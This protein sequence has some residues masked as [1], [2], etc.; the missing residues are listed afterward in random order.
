MYLNLIRQFGTV[1]FDVS[2]DR[3]APKLVTPSDV[4]CGSFYLGTESHEQVQKLLV[5]LLEHTASMP[6]KKAVKVIQKKLAKFR[7]EDWRE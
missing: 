6:P 5:A 3:I 2:D 4:Y 1:E 7:I